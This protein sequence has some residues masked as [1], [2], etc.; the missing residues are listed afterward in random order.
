MLKSA[1]PYV[2]KLSRFAKAAP[3]TAGIMTALKA[4]KV[5]APTVVPEGVE[6]TPENIQKYG[7]LLLEGGNE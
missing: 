4:G 1:W 5:E 2:S 7:N 3:W 6:V